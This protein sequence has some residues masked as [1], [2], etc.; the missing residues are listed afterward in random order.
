[1]RHLAFMTL[2]TAGVLSASA[3]PARVQTADD[4]IEKHIAAVGGRA[5]LGKL[6]SRQSTGT[7]VLTVQGQ[8]ISG[9]YESSAK[10]P[11]KSRVVIKL[12]TIP[13]GGPGEMVI[14]QRFDGVNGIAINSMQGDTPITGAQLD[15]MRN[16]AF[17]SPFLTYK[18][19]GVTLEVL[20][21]EKVGDK[22]MIVV[23]L[24]PKAGS[25]A[26]LYFDPAT[27]LIVR[28]AAK[29]SSPELGDFEQVV[30][31]LDYRTVDGV[32]VAFQTVNNTPM[33][34]V[35]TKLDKVVHNVTLDDAM[36]TKK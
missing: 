23:Q 32:K 36:F 1:M 18:E 28:T 8:D 31:F 22:E 24:T 2:L 17:P 19:R 26:K 9:P 21:R 20:P 5:A 3:A 27:F 7:A 10:A 35:V 13:L 16:G 6:T 34:R 14:D 30:E 29:V 12:D 25:V 15:N 4:I 11:N 33:Q